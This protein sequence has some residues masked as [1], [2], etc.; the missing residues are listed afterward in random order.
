MKSD[1]PN[2]Y[3]PRYAILARR[4]SNIRELGVGS[5][6]WKR[7]GLKRPCWHGAVLG[8]YGRVRLIV[9]SKT[10]LDVSYRVLT[11]SNSAWALISS[12]TD[13]EGTTMIVNSLPKYL[14]LDTTSPCSLCLS[15]RVMPLNINLNRSGPLSER[16]VECWG[17]SMG[18]MQIDGYMVV[19]V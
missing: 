15:F 14:K 13:L 16:V 10:K 8:W 7:M 2:T 18:R 9:R 19:G 3:Y 4:F 11:L 5:T 12:N 6:A 1:D 17:L